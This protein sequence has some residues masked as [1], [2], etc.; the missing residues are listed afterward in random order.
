MFTK[1]DKPAAVFSVCF[2]LNRAVVPKHGLCQQMLPDLEQWPQLC[3]GWKELKDDDRTGRSFWTQGM[4]KHPGNSEWA[5]S[6]LR[7]AGELREGGER[8]HCKAKEDI[9]HCPNL[10][11]CPCSN[12]TYALVI[13][14]LLLSTYYVPSIIFGALLSWLSLTITPEDR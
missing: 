13:L 4:A 2:Y 9:W 7:P 10:C 6:P 14:G 3:S 1:A 5:S 11:L 8:A 12:R